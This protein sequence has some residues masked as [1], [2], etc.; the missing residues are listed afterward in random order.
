MT[1]RTKI[2]DLIFLN[3]KSPLPYK[4]VGKR[5]GATQVENITNGFRM[6]VAPSRIISI[7]QTENRKKEIESILERNR[8][9]GSVILDKDDIDEL[10]LELDLINERLER[11][12]G[13]K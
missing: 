6:F 2:G 9:S 5:P 1:A 4:V 12:K 3:S 8:R 13:V 10:Q 11:L 7:R